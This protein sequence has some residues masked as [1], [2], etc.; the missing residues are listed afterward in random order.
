MDFDRKLPVQ[1]EFP[2]SL[3]IP[4]LLSAESEYT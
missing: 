1:A 2:S 4:L 3:C